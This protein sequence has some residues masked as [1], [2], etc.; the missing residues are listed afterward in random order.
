MV[1]L[2]PHAV[3]TGRKSSRPQW[4]VFLAL[5]GSVCVA[6]AE[7]S[8][9]DDNELQVEVGFTA[10]D[11]VTRAKT[12]ADILS[13]SSV[14]VT[15]GKGLVFPV[16]EHSRLL[17]TGSVTGERFQNYRGLSHVGLTVESEYQY[18]ES[19]EFDAPTFGVFARFTAEDY[20]SD[21]RDGYR[22]SL[23]L[24]VR[25]P[26]TDRIG[27]FA[28]I[29]H[30]Q[31]FGRS[32]VF[33]TMDSSLRF[34]FDYALSA[35]GTIYM[36]AEYRRGDIV[37]TGRASLENVTISKVF[38]ADDAFPGG[39]FF[40]YQLYGT[41]WLTNVGYNIAL[42]PRTALDFSWRRVESTPD[43]RPSWATSAKSYVAN[44]LF[45]SYLLRF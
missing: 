25:Q 26:L 17:V 42:G 18:R 9:D 32:A 33:D 5:W 45:V 23:G 27:F 16:S 29:A 8:H 1:V 2:F 14:N 34:N 28:A 15:F 43:L 41:T 39:Q 40:S 6:R 21:L 10:D 13:D 36:G 35:K 19:S 7:A 20:D 11:N 37:S 12:G 24:S 31:R 44:Q 4:L 38:V 22:Y 3:K 30:N